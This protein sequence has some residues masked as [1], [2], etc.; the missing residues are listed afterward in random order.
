MLLG[1][2]CTAEQQLLVANPQEA[3]VVR[4]VFDLVIQHGKLSKVRDELNSL[5]HRTK[6][7][8]VTTSS[9]QRKQVGNNRFSFDAIKSIVEN[10]IYKGFIRYQNHL[11]P[12]MHKPL[13][14]EEVWKDANTALAKYKPRRKLIGL[15]P[16]DNYVHLLKGL[17]KCGDCG[18][19]MTPYPAGKKVRTGHQRGTI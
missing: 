19:T 15:M 11:Y 17:I 14:S 10:P 2:D 1:Y 12:G 13:V 8:I 5:G 6:S 16:K 3:K 4:K 9:G 7:R 18:S